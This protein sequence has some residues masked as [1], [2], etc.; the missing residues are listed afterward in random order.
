MILDIGR[1]CKKVTGREA[2]KYC[3][4]LDKV[5]KNT[6]LVDGDVKRGNVNIAHL[7]PLPAVVK[8]KQGAKT[9]EVLEALDQ[10]GF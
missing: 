2:G 6:V 4:V 9:E 8:V 3:I 5:D 10:A 7:E 1:V